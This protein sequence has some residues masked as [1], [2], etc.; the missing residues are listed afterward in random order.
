[1][2]AQLL[3]GRCPP[4]SGFVPAVRLRGAHITGRL[5]VSGGM[6]GCELRLERCRLART[7]TFANAQ[8]RQLRISDCRLPGFDG[9]GVRVDGYLSLSGSVIDGEVR[10][11]RA[12]LMG[13]FRM[14]GTKVTAD[15]PARWALFS[16]GLLVEVGTFIRNAEFTGGVRLV[17]ARM[18]GGLFLEGSTFRNPGRL[19]LDAQ[20]IVVE[21]TAEF[22]NGFTADGTVRLRGA[23]VNGTLSFS[24]AGRLRS[25][26][27][28]LALHGSH[29]QVSELILWPEQ[30]IEG[31]LSLSYSR[32]GVI[33]DSPDVWP[34][35]MLLNGLTY[36]TL[37][38]CPPA[39]RLAWVG[40]DPEF[41]LQPYEQLA[42]WY[43]QTGHEELARSAR[44]AKQRARRA[45]LGWN[46]RTAGHL[47]DWSVGYGY[48]PWR[49]AMW[50]ALLAVAGTV[51]FSAQEPQSLRPQ[52]ERPHFNA[53][54]YTID[55]LIPIGTFGQ[56]DAWDPVGWTQWFAYGL[57]VSGWLLATA[58]IAGVTR[59]VR[60]A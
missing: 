13:G 6:V 46:G 31:R 20:N 57:I 1:V 45:T 28:R 36:E 58:L 29:M 48:R 51:V 2:I 23:R 17:G 21:D 3:L 52:G 32:I 9:G 18:N 39:E 7:P 47:L 5:D 25:T 59:V 24:R 34:D 26:S 35:E 11:P 22:S 54:I 10:L 38:G 16:G 14:N 56:R 43:S 55:L 50:F 4:R 8:T 42:A 41:H 30:R 37:R 15:D 40:R 12:Q 19:A 53:L 49:A 33:L 60:P 44:L 27:G